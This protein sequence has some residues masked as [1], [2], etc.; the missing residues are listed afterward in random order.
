MNSSLP[1]IV[2]VSIRP[3]ASTRLSFRLWSWVCTLLAV[4]WFAVVPVSHAQGQSPPSPRLNLLTSD[5]HAI[6]FEVQI[7]EPE[8]EIVTSNG[9]PHSV[10]TVPSYENVAL[11]GM[12]QLP[13]K[14]VLVGIPPGININLNVRVEVTV[15]YPLSYPVM[16]APQQQ[17]VPRRDGVDLLALD[18]PLRYV[19]VEEIPPAESAFDWTCTDDMGCVQGMYPGHFATLVET[20]YLR[21]QAIASIRLTPVQVRPATRELVVAQRF[22]VELTFSGRPRPAIRT[23]ESGPFEE[24]LRSALVNYE[25]A[26]NW[27][28]PE[29]GAVSAATTT[30]RLPGVV[31]ASSSQSTTEYKIA[32]DETGVV[33]LS[34]TDLAAAGFPVGDVDPR[35]IHMRVGDDEIAIWVQGEDDG[36]LDPGDAILFYGQR[37]ETRYT[38]TNIY[39]LWVDDTPGLRMLSLPAD[40]NVVTESVDRFQE[41]QHF[42]EDRVYLSDVPRREGADHW[43]WI[44]YSAGRPTSR[45]T[46]EFSFDAPGLLPEGT[47]TFTMSVQGT[48]SYFQVNP[49]HHLRFYINDHQI[50]DAY[51]DG[52]GAW[53]DALRFDASLLQ[54]EGN[55]LRVQAVTDTG[56]AEDV[57]YINWFDIS[58]PRSLKAQDDRLAF[59]LTGDGNVRVQ[60]TGFSESSPLLFDVT[61][62][63]HPRRL[64]GETV[65]L[66][67]GAYTLAAGITLAGRER[68]WAGTTN[69]MLSAL[70]IAKDAP[71]NWRSPENSADYII[72]AH[73][74]TMTAAQRLANYRAS[75]GYRVAVVDVQDVYDEFNGG[76][77]SAEAIRDFLQYAYYNWERPAPTYV[78]LLGDGT[79]DFKNNEG[80]GTPTLIPPLLRLVD[81]FLGE[82]ATDNRYVTVSGDDPLPDMLIGR[83]PANSEDEAMTMVEKTMTYETNPPPGDW[84][85]RIVFVADNADQAGDFA[86]LS[87]LVADNLVPDIYSV[88]KLYLGVNYTNIIE[89][90][91]AIKEAYDR[92]ALIFNYVGHATIPWWAAE[93]LFS[94]QTIPQLENGERTP[95]NLPMT[96]LDGYFHAAGL[97]SLGESIV[98]ASGRGAVASWSATGLGVAHGH[99]FLHRGFY[100]ALFYEDKRVLGTATLAGKLNLYQGDTGGFFHD[101]IDTYIVLGDPALRI[102]SY[103][104][105]IS[106]QGQAPASAP[107]LGDSFEVRFDVTNQGLAPASSVRVTLTVPA[108]VTFAAASLNGTPLVP[109]STHPLAFDLGDIDPG[110]S[111]PLTAVFHTDELNPPEGRSFSIRAEAHTTWTEDDVTNNVTQVDITLLAADVRVQVNVEPDAPVSPGGSIA[112]HITYENLGP[113]RSPSRTLAFP[114]SGLVNSSFTA[115][116]ARVVMVGDVPYTWRLPPL[117]AGANGS[118]DILAVVDPTL[119]LSRSPLVLTASL[120][121][122]MYDADEDNNSD[123]ALVVVLFA[124]AYEP[125]DTP[126]Q[127]TFLSVPG[128]S[129]NHTHHTADDPDWFRFT[130]VA[131]RVYLIHITALGAGADTVMT[132]YDANLQILSQNDNATAGVTWS[133]IRWRAP[134]SGIYYVLITPKSGTPYGRK[135]TLSIDVALGVYVPLYLSGF[136]QPLPTPSPTPTP[137]PTFTLTPTSTPTMTPTPTPTLSHTPTPTFSPTFAFTPTPPVTPTPTPTAT[138][139]PT[140][141][142]TLTPT[143]SPTPTWTSLPPGEVCLPLSRGKVYVG[144]HPKGIAVNGR[145]VYVGLYDGGDVAVVDGPG[146]ER[147]DVWDSPG[148]G[149]NAVLVGAGRVFMTHR[150]SH[151]I[152]VFDEASGE[153]MALWPTGLLPWGMALVDDTLYVSNYA[154]DT[155]SLF[156]VR[157]GTQIRQTMVGDKPAML[158]SVDESVYVPLVGQGMIRLADRGTS[159]VAVS[160]VGTGMI[161]VVGDTGRGLV[162]GSRRD[163][164]EIV[165]VNHHTASLLAPIAVPGRPV[166]LALSPNGRWLYGVDPFADQLLIVDTDNQRWVASLALPDQGDDDGGQGI[167]VGEGLLYVTNYGDGTVS[168]Y[169]LPACAR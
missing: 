124:D 125:D 133:A 120:D 59:S 74:L 153:L 167:A 135:Y 168:V 60:I 80:T 102:A 73:R 13:Q 38:N 134:E 161:D 85:Q 110:Q 76:V 5:E 7:P 8:I 48:S 6:R 20:G 146:M 11:P 145:R 49:D 123:A 71:S 43:Y 26:R 126:S 22:V 28:D 53:T 16:L 149:A 154:S 115:S 31:T 142:P 147:M 165:V 29:H 46:R 50:G 157:S 108:H 77:M 83:M 95:V 119:T 21:D 67:G 9:V 118:I 37:M 69:A 121:S 160:G 33:R 66:S 2:A 96:C 106:I 111:L 127:S 86:Q 163:G 54:P 159:K 82:T 113:G 97:S 144:G 158:A 99:D 78:L 138:G 90:R 57:G 30:A 15:T 94:T 107:S 62:P 84:L 56:A 32:V 64:L 52:L 70:S 114:L 18:T 101:L 55:I 130:A 103:T 156:D 17:P 137:T 23:A 116:D 51:W 122:N 140:L 3:K 81:P 4:S 19:G 12:P 92:G 39:W 34:T 45:P 47:A 148:S 109:V 24:I 36:R 164:H 93:V 152:A 63:L 72:I 141:M 117:E 65:P 169:E 10:V 68:Y 89:L 139:T 41:R 132:L 87:N 1:D 136:T 61:D 166:G 151:Q 27:R 79:Y 75:Q 150:N 128:F 35:Y 112:F 88:E 44:Y 91:A 162:Y 105:D 40:P 14:G 104:A 25:Q 129:P 131:G 143:P 58:Y 155:V 42:E 98:R 100:R